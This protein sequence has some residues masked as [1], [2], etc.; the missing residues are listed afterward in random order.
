MTVVEMSPDSDLADKMTPG[1]III[2]LLP[3]GPVTPLNVHPENRKVKTGGELPTSQSG[4]ST[5]KTDCVETANIPTS[6]SL[7][8]N[9]E[10]NKCAV[11][12]TK[13]ST[14]DVKQLCGQKT[15]SRGTPTTEFATCVETHYR[16]RS[17][18]KPKPD[19]QKRLPHSVSLNVSYEQDDSANSENDKSPVTKKCTKLR[20]KKE[21]SSARIKVVNFITKLPSVT[22]LGR[23]AR[24]ITAKSDAAPE[25]AL[26]SPAASTPPS[27]Y[28]NRR[29]FQ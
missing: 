26:K 12:W 23:S 22:P 5:D 20:P 18:V 4:T 13:L 28:Y 24:N 8:E 11:K 14:E 27:K 16:T 15:T 21:P 10:L 7:K 29:H 2:L 19:Y 9:V 17:S 25:P 3:S 1:S 6:S